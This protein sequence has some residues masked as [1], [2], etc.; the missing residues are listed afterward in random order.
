MWDLT[1]ANDHDFYI[2]TVASDILV[3]NCPEDPYLDREGES[4]VCSKHF[5]GGSQVDRSKGIFNI[6]EDPYSLADAGAGVQPEGP[7]ANGF[8][9][10]VVNA[11]RI[12]GNTS[13]DSGGLPTTTYR[14]VHDIW[15]AVITMFPE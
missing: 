5:P 6:N 4:Y 14:I 10:R 7:N 15:G 9:E 8:Y 11:G 2:H 13:E 1:I 12:I 3:H